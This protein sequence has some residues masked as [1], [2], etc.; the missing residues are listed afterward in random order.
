MVCRCVAKLW[1]M[2]NQ[3]KF[4]QVNIY[5]GKYM[6][7]LVDFLNKEKPDIV[8]MQEVTAG[9]VNYFED[10]TINTFEYI[11][12]KTG[13]NGYFYGDLEF[14]DS[15]DSLFGNAVLTK[16]KPVDLKVLSLKKYRPL[17]LAEFEDSTIWPEISRLAIDATVEIE[18]INVHAISW[19]G[20]WTAPPADTQETLRQ[21]QMV[22]DYLK[23][24]NE[25]F[26]VGVD[27]N[28]VPESRTVGIINSVANNLM[29]GAGVMQT[30]HPKLH[31]IAPRGYLVDYIFVSKDFKVVSLK[32]PQVTISDHLPVVAT[33]EL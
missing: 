18:G 22:A 32:V 33:L 15:S 5:K 12:E 20:A 11:K 31:K 14:V 2:K 16:H 28:N 30:T 7:S 23:N 29:A 25:P 19:H 4:I 13:L 17:T 24:L 26:I 1:L 8:A 27:I 3:I 10:K 21:A 6:D 9:E